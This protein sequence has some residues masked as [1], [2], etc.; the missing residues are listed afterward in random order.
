MPSNTS[1][2]CHLVNR[3]GTLLGHLRVE[4]EIMPNPSMSYK[5]TVADKGSWNLC[6]LS[7]NDFSRK[8]NHQHQNQMAKVMKLGSV[9]NLLEKV[10]EDSEN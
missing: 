8:I 6:N 10:G 4:R 9:R 5:N 7:H 3:D 2:H 1:E